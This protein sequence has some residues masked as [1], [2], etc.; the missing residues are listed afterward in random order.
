MAILMM[1]EMKKGLILTIV[2]FFGL[3]SY[4][5]TVNMVSDSM[6]QLFKNNGL[7]SSVLEKMVMR[8]DGISDSLN[9][10]YNPHL[11]IT[12]LDSSE[13]ML[14]LRT[15]SS[16]YKIVL[17]WAC[18]SKSGIAEMIQNKYLFD[19]TL[20]SI[21]LVSSDL[22]ND[23]QRRVINKFLTSL[24]IS[25]DIYQ[26]NSK[27]DLTDLQNT[28]AATSFINYMTGGKKPLIQLNA[29]IGIPYALIYDRDN[30][31]ARTYDGHFSFSE[32]AKFKRISE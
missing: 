27:T 14:L 2:L 5:Q 24:G 28:R 29:C 13:L 20:Y 25:R 8:T 6:A 19:T 30:K 16:Y 31:I 4:S 1:K 11:K 21:Y 7:S 10:V 12:M 17:L 26:I 3:I 22:N 9:P 15:D 18:W 32:L 23:N